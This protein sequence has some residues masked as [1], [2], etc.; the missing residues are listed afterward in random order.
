MFITNEIRYI[1]VN[2]HE[3]DL[4]VVDADIADLVGNEHKGF[5]PCIYLYAYSLPHF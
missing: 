5:P 1:G 3:V 4:M 2:D